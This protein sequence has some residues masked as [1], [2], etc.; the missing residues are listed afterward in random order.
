MNRMRNLVLIAVLFVTVSA[1]AGGLLHAR[2]SKS[3]FAPNAFPKPVSNRIFSIPLDPATLMVVYPMAMEANVKGMQALL[4][5]RCGRDIPFRSADSLTPEALSGKDLIV[6][7]NIS[8][9]RWAL[10]LYKQRYSF[11]DAVFPGKGGYFIHPATS[12][13]DRRRNVLVIGVSSDSD[14][15]PGFEAFVGVL[16]QGADRIESIHRVK[17]SV[18]FPR[19]P[20]SVAKIFDDVRKNIWIAIPPYGAIANWGMNYFFTGDRKWAEHFRDGSASFMTGPKRP[21]IGSPNSGPASIS[22]CGAWS[23]HGTSSTTTPSLR[24]RIE[25]SSRRRS[26]DSQ[27]S[28]GA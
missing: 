1:S 13:W 8:N 6:V 15:V 28:C 3:V 11:A 10:E 18:E 23:W 26:G 12:I 4:A 19:P 27:V 25:K 7:G 20:E 5:S 2:Y 14:S 22:P 24:F 9:N 21:G 17:T 16:P